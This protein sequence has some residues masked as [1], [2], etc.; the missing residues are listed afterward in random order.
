[1]LTLILKLGMLCA[2]EPERNNRGFKNALARR[3][4]YIVLVVVSSNIR[5]CRD[6]LL[7]LKDSY[8]Y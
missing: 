3:T 4:D 2:C 7:V 8:G 6:V 1:M 5:T